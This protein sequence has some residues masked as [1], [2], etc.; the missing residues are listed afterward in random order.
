MRILIVD[1]EAPAR[2]R[3]AEQIA[4]IDGHEVVGQAVDGAQALRRCEELSPDVVLLDIRMPG[5]DGIETARHMNTLSEPPAVIFTT[6]YDQ[7]AVEAFDAE[8]VGYLLKPIRRI[9][10]EKA[11]ERAARL[12][13]LQ[14]DRLAASETASPRRHLCVRAQDELKLIPVRDI[15]YFQADQ[16]YVR[17]CHRHGVDLLDESLKS[18]EKEFSPNF[19]RIHRNSLVA[20]GHLSGLDKDR[21]GGAVVR[22]RHIDDTLPVSRRHLAEIR[23]R[24]KGGIA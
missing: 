20:T 12:T 3:L 17:I 18:L 19:C 10:L 22:F 15:Y 8:A 21:R 5:M 23:Q 9:R 13:G 16:K 4:Q 11:L 14:L 6:A 7:Y 24:L 2:R 1:D